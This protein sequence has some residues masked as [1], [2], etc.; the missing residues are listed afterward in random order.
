MKSRRLENKD[1]NYE[2]ACKECLFA[3]Y[4]GKT[5]TGC[6]LGR[7]EKFQDLGKVIDAY[8]DEKEFYVIEGVCNAV[9]QPSWNN[10]VADEG[11]LRNEIR[12]RFNVLFAASDITDKILEEWTK[13]YDDTQD[14]DFEVDWTVIAE[15][16]LAPEKRAMIGKFLRHTNASV[17]SSVSL[18]FSMYEA[19][20]K[21][22]RAF[23]VVVDSP[24]LPNAN[25]FN[26]IDTLL[27]DDLEKFVT[28]TLNGTCAVSN[29]AFH[30]YQ[31]KI[32]SMNF[33]DILEAVFED[34]FELKLNI[35][36]VD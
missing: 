8:D 1:N 27:N 24:S 2:T 33:Y 14:T 3:M 28:Y 12:P 10:A 29:L 34:A 19:V 32:N 9:R 35:T 13:F 6:T 23:S 22:R 7:I 26:R 5:Q 21:S 15:S 16:A 30:V 36:E 18:G 25:I 4:D 17:V 31:K 20:M 11:K